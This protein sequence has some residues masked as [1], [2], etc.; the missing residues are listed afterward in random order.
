MLSFPHSTL[1]MLLSDMLGVVSGCGG[2]GEGVVLVGMP[3]LNVHVPV[4]EQSCGIQSALTIY[5]IVLLYGSNDNYH[6][7][8]SVE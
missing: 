3:H 8:Q 7:V 2:E 6:I 1:S 5:I 4:W